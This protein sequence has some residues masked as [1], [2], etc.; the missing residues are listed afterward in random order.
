MATVNIPSQYQTLKTRLENVIKKVIEPQYVPNGSNLNNYT[1]VGMYYNN[2]N[3]E[4]TNITNLPNNNHSAFCLS[5]EEMGGNARKQTL[6]FQGSNPTVF[7]REKL[8]DNS[9]TSWF[10]IPTNSA[11]NWTSQTI[12]TYG[13][14]HINTALR[15]CQFRYNR[16]GYNFSS[17]GTITLHS[18][19]I[20]SDYRPKFTTILAVWN[21]T[22]GM[23]VETDGNL[24]VNSATTG[25][26]N[27]SATG[28]WHY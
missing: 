10:Q 24:I 2:A 13:T 12:A 22:I 11:S 8:W 19:A 25:S 16:S 14:L 26:K 23:A 20:P 9:W 4:T 7:V 28:M 18:G 1:D 6:T 21:S 3:A 17:T 5:V 15:L 27:I